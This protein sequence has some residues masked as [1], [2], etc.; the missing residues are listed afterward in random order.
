VLLV[1]D[2]PDMRAFLRQELGDDYDIEEAVDGADGLARAIELV[3]DLV[4]TDAMMP[5]MDGFELVRRLRAD[6][7][8]SHVPIV[9]LTARTSDDARIAGL[10]SGVDDYLPK[11][12][13]AR[14]LRM[15]VRNLLEIRRLLR[16]RYAGEIWLKPEEVEAPSVDREFLEKVARIVE[17][18]ISDHTLTVEDLAASVHMSRSQLHRKLRALLGR[19]PGALIRGMRLQRAADLVTA[20]DL[21]LGQVAYAVGFSDQAHF[22][23]SFKKHF[24]CTPSAYRQAR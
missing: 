6:A 20:G 22:T 13:S 16:A 18:R 9:M 5:R 7:R 2:H 15:R 4:I 11:P 1:E 12:F 3:P 21:Q 19:T 8:T 10:E 23:R 14:V 17:E 24:G